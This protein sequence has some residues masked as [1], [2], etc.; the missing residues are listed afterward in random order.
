M[1]KTPRIIAPLYIGT[2]RHA[3]MKAIAKRLQLR[4]SILNHHVAIKK[5]DKVA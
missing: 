5:F 1:A 4:N 3:A 2:P